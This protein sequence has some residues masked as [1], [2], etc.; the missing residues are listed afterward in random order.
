MCAPGFM[1]STTDVSNFVLLKTIGSLFFHFIL[2]YYIV[3]SWFNVEN[4]IS[5]EK[6]KSKEQNKV[7]R[8]YLCRNEQINTDK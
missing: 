2:L 1:Q 5:N 3:L 7:E 6:A 4:K 8:A